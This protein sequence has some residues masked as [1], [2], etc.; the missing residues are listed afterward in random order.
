[1]GDRRVCRELLGEDANVD[2]FT[3]FCD[4]K[5]DSRE[6]SLDGSTDGREVMSKP[7]CIYEGDA[8]SKSKLIRT[9]RSLSLEKSGDDSFTELA[10]LVEQ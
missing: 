10:N 9:K 6:W 4:V 1:M 7:V 3:S 8:C 5:E 2:A